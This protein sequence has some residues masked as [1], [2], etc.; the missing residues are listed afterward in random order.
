[1]IPNFLIIGA[2]RAG[3]TWMAENLR[4]HPQI[5]MPK[6]K[7]L[8]F[9]DRHY[10]RGW[11]FYEQ[12][13]AA[14]DGEPAI[15][16]A[17]PEYLYL[18]RIPRLIYKHL[19]HA[20]LIVSLRNPVDR[21]YSRYWN[22]KAKY[23]ENRNLSFEDKLKKKPLFLEEGFYYDHLLRYYEYF[24]REQILVLL[25]DE[26]RSDPISFLKKVYRFLDVR[27]DFVSDRLQ[28]KINAAADKPNLARSWTL[29]YLQKAFR[30]LNWLKAYRITSNVNSATLPAMREETRRWLVNDVY[31][32]KND[33]LAELIQ[34]DLD[35]WNEL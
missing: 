26:L 19:P 24:P 4:S 20:K 23:K 31:R 29:A 2:P 6:E 27:E 22:A 11:D 15:G 7:E 30:R 17:T 3:T 21:V 34:Q 8:H 32:Q 28:Q 1:M 25:F 12:F 35:Q 5:Y 18:P 16:E 13:F 10:E 9:F 33:K 14:A